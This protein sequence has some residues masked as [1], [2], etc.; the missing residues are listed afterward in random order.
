MRSTR[1]T[2]F[3]LLRKKIIISINVNQRISVYRK[4]PHCLR[5]GAL[6]NLVTKLEA[7]SALGDL[8]HVKDKVTS[9]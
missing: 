1:S 4:G 9:M 2:L 3:L 6:L 5:M 7:P 8:T